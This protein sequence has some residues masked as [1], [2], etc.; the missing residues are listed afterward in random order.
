M[1]YIKNILYVDYILRITSIIRLW[2]GTKLKRNYIWEHANKKSKISMISG[3][4]GQ[5]LSWAPEP[6]LPQKNSAPVQIKASFFAPMVSLSCLV[7]TA[8][9]SQVVGTA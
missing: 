9:C 4:A 2:W 7:L 6:F 5:G 8:S 3:T 1:L